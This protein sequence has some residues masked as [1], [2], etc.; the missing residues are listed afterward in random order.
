MAIFSRNFKW[1]SEL[2]DKVLNVYPSKV[3][4]KLGDVAR[5]VGGAG[6]V[7]S[8]IREKA[9]LVSNIEYLRADSS[10][11][12]SETGSIQEKSKWRGGVKVMQ[13]VKSV[14]G[15]LNSSM[16]IER[17]RGSSMDEEGNGNGSDEDDNVESQ[18]D[19][20]FFSAMPLPAQIDDNGLLAGA[21]TGSSNVDIAADVARPEVLL[22]E[23]G[24]PI[25][26]SYL[27]AYLVH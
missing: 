11:H 27:I 18:M 19:S 13:K 5:I 12:C 17:G 3:E 26:H 15:S 10:A 21:D 7:R 2:R 24:V 20:S 25:F 1:S 4:S 8:D 22:S 23:S 9:V 6:A 16:R 14:F